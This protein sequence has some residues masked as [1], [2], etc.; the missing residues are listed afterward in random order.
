MFN[1][2]VKA[3]ILNKSEHIAKRFVIEQQRNYYH[4]RNKRKRN[5]DK[6]FEKTFAALFALFRN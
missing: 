2:G 4:T 5:A 1:N 3:Y 6:N